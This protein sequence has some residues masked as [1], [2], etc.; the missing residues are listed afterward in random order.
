MA[1][2]DGRRS[3]N[4]DV[5]P[6]SCDVIN[7]FWEGQRKQFSTYYYLPTNSQCRSFNGL[8]VLKRGGGRIPQARDEKKPRLNRVNYVKMTGQ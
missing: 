5:V 4:G 6:T 7:S 2:Q 8:E 1:D 3:K